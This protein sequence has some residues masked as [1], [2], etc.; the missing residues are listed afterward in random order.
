WIV[1][2]YRVR[3][4]IRAA[5]FTERCAVC[6][7]TGGKGDGPLASILRIESTDLTQLAAQNEGSF[8]FER[9]YR[10]I[11][12]RAEVAA[13]GPRTMPV[14]GHDYKAITNAERS[15]YE[16]NRPTEDIVAERILALTRYLET[17]QE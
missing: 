7:G 11:D 16:R 12:G 4:R 2:R 1:S 6:H 10:V 9:V 3:A 17:I 5:E 14:W 13:H 8:P 15:I